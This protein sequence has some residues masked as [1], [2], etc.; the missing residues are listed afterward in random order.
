MRISLFVITIILSCKVKHNF[1]NLQ[2]FRLKT[3]P[4][5]SFIKPEVILKLYKDSFILVKYLDPVYA[6]VSKGIVKY[7]NGQKKLIVKENVNISLNTGFPREENGNNSKIYYVSNIASNE[8]Q[9]IKSNNQKIDSSFISQPFKI[10]TEIEDREKWFFTD[11]FW[12]ILKK[13]I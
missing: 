7:E 10:I 13:Q 8:I 5:H 11:Q 12:R 9:I 2:F 3:D 4:Y 1:V 6:D